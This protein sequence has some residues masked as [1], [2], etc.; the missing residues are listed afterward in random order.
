[1]IEVDIV[2]SATD[3]LHQINTQSIIFANYSNQYD[4][5]LYDRFAC[6]DAR[7]Y[8]HKGKPS[9]TAI[10]C[11]RMCD[12]ELT[13]PLLIHYHDIR[14]RNQSL[15]DGY[16]QYQHR[17]D[18]MYFYVGYFSQSNACIA[19]RFR[20]CSSTLLH[21]LWYTYSY[22]YKPTTTICFGIYTFL[23]SHHTGPFRLL[24]CV[25]HTTTP[26]TSTPLFT[27]SSFTSRSTL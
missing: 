13:Q 18:L 8:I 5:N 6:G 9:A 2:Q 14:Y 4:N 15:S 11:C 24:P 7:S 20:E 3:R 16:D 27:T 22:I 10:S 17:L 19:T 21:K 1:M 23:N 26:S 25:K 12:F